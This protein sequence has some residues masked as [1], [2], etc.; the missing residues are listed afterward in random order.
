[1]GGNC[2]QTIVGDITL[3]DLSIDRLR[4][5]KTELPKIVKQQRNRFIETSKQIEETGQ[6]GPLNGNKFHSGRRRYENS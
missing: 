6:D 4:C 1:M 3:K 5:G 2:S